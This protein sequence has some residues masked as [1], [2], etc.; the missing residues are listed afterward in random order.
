[1][2]WFRLYHGTISDPKWTLISR[3]AKVSIGIV[4]SVWL[5]LLEHASQNAPRGSIIGYD[6]E[7]VDALFG[8]DDGTTQRVIEAMR[9]SGVL[10]DGAIA[11]WRKRQPLREDMTRNE[12]VARHREKQRNA[13]V[14][15]GN[16]CNVQ[17]QNRTEQRRKEQKKKTQTQESAPAEIAAVEIPAVLDTPA[18]RAAWAEFKMHR[19]DIKKK[20][21]HRA[22][23]IMLSDLSKYPSVAVKALHE[24]IKNGWQ[25]VFPEKLLPKQSTITANHSAYTPFGGMK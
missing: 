23:R 12:R 14:T 4:V 15:Q 18:F 21:T 6:D 16:A 13:D 20:M 5:S 9:E 7:V 2:E 17:E 19:H 10:I 25:G 22:Q 8:Y 1:M 11:S 24:S 3:K